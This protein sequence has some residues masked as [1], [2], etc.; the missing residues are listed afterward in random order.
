MPYASDMEV[1]GITVILRKVGTRT[2][3]TA[4]AV[5]ALLAVALTLGSVGLVSAQDDADCEVTDLGSLDS[6][7]N[8]RLEATGQWTTED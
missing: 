2:L 5:A 3:L 6:E 7:A 8:S 4:L 1:K